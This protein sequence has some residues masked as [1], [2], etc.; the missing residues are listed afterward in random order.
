MILPDKRVLSTTYRL[1]PLEDDL[2]RITVYPRGPAP[3]HEAT[4]RFDMF[5]AWAQDGIR[6]LDTAGPGHVVLGVGIKIGT[7]YWFEPVDK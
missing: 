4:Y 3:V 2:Y 1:V 5:P 7:N 6:M